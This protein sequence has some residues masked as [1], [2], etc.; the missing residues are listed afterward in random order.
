LNIIKDDNGLGTP[1]AIF[2][3]P[4]GE[5]VNP[6]FP[7]HFRRGAAQGAKGIGESGP[8]HVKGQPMA[9]RNSG[10]LLNLLQCVHGATL[11][12]LQKEIC[13]KI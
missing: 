11:R 7:T 1:T 2:G 9:V 5:D 8:V 3:G 10:N 4:K 12:T 13:K 6:R